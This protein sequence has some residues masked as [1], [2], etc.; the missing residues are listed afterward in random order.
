MCHQGNPENGYSGYDGHRLWED[1]YFQRGSWVVSLE[2]STY[3]FRRGQSMGPG[4]LFC[5]IAQGG[6][7]GFPK[8]KKLKLTQQRKILT[9][10]RGENFEF[11]LY[12]SPRLSAVKGRRQSISS[13]TAGETQ[14][15]SLST[16]EFFPHTF[17]YACSNSAPLTRQ[18]ILLN[19]SH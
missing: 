12:E 13:G 4:I 7:L 10:A 14:P 15:R 2:V 19:M 6:W 18:N 17:F 8:L 3:S 1:E 9:E 11:K 5:L 16:I